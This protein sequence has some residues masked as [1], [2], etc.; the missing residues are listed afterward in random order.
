LLVKESN[1]YWVKKL[2]EFLEEATANIRGTVRYYKI[3]EKDPLIS[4]SNPIVN[5]YFS[6]LNN[7]N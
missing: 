1:E 6:V 4:Q 7:A 5:P 2:P 3:E